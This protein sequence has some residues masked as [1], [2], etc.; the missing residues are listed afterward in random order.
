[1]LNAEIAAAMVQFGTAGLIGWM[2]LTERR[3]AGEREKQLEEAHEKLMQERVVVQAFLETMRENT[4]VLS[5]VEAGQRALLT[6]LA[7]WRE[8]G[9]D[10]GERPERGVR[11]AG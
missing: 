7:A 2:W 8:T 1:M 6:T 9:M 10:R 11:A 3:A 4:R 5:Q